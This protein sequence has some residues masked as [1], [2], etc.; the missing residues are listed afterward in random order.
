M[1]LLSD[2]MLSGAILVFGLVPNFLA[3]IRE[4]NKSEVRTQGLRH[5]SFICLRKEEHP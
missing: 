1:V 4:I 3:V 2:C 5:S